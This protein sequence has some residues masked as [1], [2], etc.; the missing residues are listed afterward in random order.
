MLERSYLWIA[1]SGEQLRV[2]EHGVVVV[3]CGQKNMLAS[4]HAGRLRRRRQ[5]QECGLETALLVA[6][7]NPLERVDLPVVAGRLHLHRHHRPCV[8]HS[9][10]R[11]PH[12]HCSSSLYMG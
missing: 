7:R 2:V 6:D 4:P 5:Q 11:H 3:R 10:T 8:T 1:E 9:S 12:L